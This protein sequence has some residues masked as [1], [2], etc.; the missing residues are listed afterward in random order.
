MAR[1]SYKEK[2]QIVNAVLA[3][4]MFHWER[5]LGI[6]DDDSEAW[7]DVFHSRTIED[8]W[9][10]TEYAKIEVQKYPEYMGKYKYLTSDLEQV[11]KRLMLGKPVVKPKKDAK[12]YNFTTFRF[13]MAFKD[14]LND[15]RGTPTKQYTDKER[16]LAYELANPT[17]FEAHFEFA[18]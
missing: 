12:N 3:V 4:T 11:E 5:T 16:E 8:W 6:F 1:T 9:D 15:A 2:E 14:L 18:Q 10:I 17:A 7:D 13:W